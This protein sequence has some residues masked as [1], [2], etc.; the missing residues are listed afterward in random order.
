M[1]TLDAKPAVGHEV[2]GNNVRNVASEAQYLAALQDNSVDVINLT[3]S[4]TAN[5]MGQSITRALRINGNG[6]TLTIPGNSGFGPA[7]TTASPSR[8]VGT[9]LILEGTS[10]GM[11]HMQN[12]TINR[13]TNGNSQ[14]SFISV[15]TD[16]GTNW[17]IILDN[18]NST[19][20]TNRW[21]ATVMTL[22]NV[23]NTSRVFLRN[24]VTING[25]VAAFVFTV[26]DA[27]IVED[28]A[29]FEGPAGSQAK[30]Y[31]G[32]ATT[33]TLTAPSSSLTGNRGIFSN[34]SQID[35]YNNANIT[36]LASA[37]IQIPVLSNTNIFNTT[38]MLIR[39]D[40]D[41]SFRVQHQF[42][43]SALQSTGTYALKLL[44]NPG[45][46]VEMTSTGG[47]DTVQL[48]TA[49]SEFSLSKP[50]YFNIQNN[51]TGR[52]FSGINS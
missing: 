21:R 13:A 44:G 30:A 4:F 46:T 7:D 40:T 24:N 20:N 42:N 52:A 15:L 49:G 17:D 36:L 28:N 25:G 22:S 27:V 12:I 6:N 48:A 32:N 29:V 14:N 51:G 34:L 11:L 35:V 41:A 10:G 19:F 31:F 23:T 26:S 3:T 8:S 9:H 16:S 33:A 5:V 45:S 18:F 1:F 38:D 2:A 50:K 39:V 37:N 47:N 43:G